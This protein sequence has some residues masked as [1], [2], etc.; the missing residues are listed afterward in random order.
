[1]NLPRR[2]QLVS[3]VLS[4]GASVAAAQD[5]WVYFGT[6]TGA[7]SQGVYV[8]RLT[9]DG[10]LTAPELA[11]ASPNPAFLAVDPSHHFLYAANE[12][13]N[14][15]GGKSGSVSAFA[16]D[17]HTG[18]LTALNQLSTVGPGPAHVSVDATGKVVMVANYGGGSVASFPV[19]P[20]GSL[21]AAASFFQMHGSSVNPARQQEPHGHFVT[22]DP[23]NRFA[24]MC[25]LG[26]DQVLVF[27][28]DPAAGTL[29][30]NDP[31][32]ARLK[33]GAGPR[34][35]AFRPDGKFVYVI[36]ELDCT[37]T[38][39]AYDAAHGT[40]AEV[41]SI[42]TLPPGEEV[43]KN[44]STAEVFVHPNGKFLY[45]SNR[46]HDSLAVFSIDAATGKLTLVEHLPSGG[47]TPRN[48]NLDPAGRFLLSANQDSGNVVV[49]RVDEKTGRLTPTGDS[50]ELQKPVC[51]VFVPVE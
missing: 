7:K 21:G 39:F 32:F 14:F 25:D 37:L 19:N 51:V 29:T 4:L 22:A 30:P 50:V 18:R 1:M 41:Q 5:Y 17:A 2:L 26:L 47:K 43:R 6:Y 15:A 28:L 33:P 8:S 20:D 16:L 23:T 48:F 11:A 38:A 3:V 35:L 27:K 31:P 49:F 13:G 24:L 45:G 36:N 46:G 10:R 12:I 42:S 34:H 44:Y 9:A 40:L